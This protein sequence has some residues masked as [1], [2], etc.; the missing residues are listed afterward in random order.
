MTPCDATIT[1]ARYVLP[2]LAASITGL[3]IKAINRKIETGVWADGKQYHKAPDGRNYIDM[4][5]Y[6]SWVT[7]RA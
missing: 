3:T 5:G 4:K 1:P 2:H 6:E 7:R